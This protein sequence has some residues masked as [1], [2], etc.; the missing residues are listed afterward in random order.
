MALTHLSVQLLSLLATV[1]AVGFGTAAKAANINVTVKIENLAPANSVSYAPLHL[2]LNNDTFDAL[3]I[4]AVAVAGIV[5]VADGRAGTVWQPDFA[6]ADLTADLTPTSPPAAAPS[7]TFGNLRQPGGRPSMRFLVDTALNPYSTSAAMLVPNNDFFVG[8]D[9][10]TEHKRFNNG[11]SRL[12]RRSPR[13]LSRVHQ[14]SHPAPR[15]VRPAPCSANV[16]QPSQQ[17]FELTALQSDHQLL[18]RERF[19]RGEL[20]A[21]AAQKF[22]LG[23]RPPPVQLAR[24]RRAGWSWTATCTRS[25]AH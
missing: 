18:H 13:G 19:N 15:A 3:N 11:G 23:A 12:F 14:A 8:N 6:A 24:R 5:S 22:E 20:V 10:P 7:T 1:A 21:D 16:R 9:S 2:G 25:S 17:L 4:G